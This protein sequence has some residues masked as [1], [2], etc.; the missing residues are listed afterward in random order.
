[1]IKSYSELLSGPL[2][3]DD[4]DKLL[5]SSLSHSGLVGFK[6]G[7]VS[8]TKHF[9][10]ILMLNTLPTVPFVFVLIIYAFC[11]RMYRSG[12]KPNSFKLSCSIFG[13]GGGINLL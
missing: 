5:S 8:L 10:S 2:D 4:D 6:S 9:S 1:V 11:I 7:K 3:N 13:G 12:T